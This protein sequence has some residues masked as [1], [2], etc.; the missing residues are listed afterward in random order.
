MAVFV[1]TDSLRVSELLRVSHYSTNA[2]L[3]RA[4]PFQAS[5]LMLHVTHGT[6]SS[7][8]AHASDRSVRIEAILDVQCVCVHIVVRACLSA[9]LCAFVPVSQPACVR[10]CSLFPLLR[11]LPKLMNPAAVRTIL[12]G[13]M[14]G[15]RTSSPWAFVT[16]EVRP[17]GER[18]CELVGV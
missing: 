1:L 9:C 10:L 12:C 5:L 7:F 17:N 15:M 11:G 4:L 16:K 18:K 13:E 14:V 3:C 8:A 2:E 6:L